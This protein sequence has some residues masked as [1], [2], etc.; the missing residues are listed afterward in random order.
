MTHAPDTLTALITGGS[1]GLG[2][3]CALILARSGHRL[4]LVSENQKELARA[5]RV[6]LDAGAARADTIC[7][8]LTTRDAAERLHGE[9][10][11]RGLVIDVLINC[12]GIYPTI[13]R[14]LTDISCIDAVVNLHVLAL[15]KLCLLFGRDM[16]ARRRGYILNVS[17]IASGFPDPASLTYGPS[18][19]YVRSF[20]EAIHCEWKEYGVK[21][22]CMTPG[23]ISTNFFTA[24]NVFIPP[25]IRR[26]L[27][28]AEDCARAG[29][30][31]MF[32]GTRRVTPGLYG[33]LQ[34]VILSII[35]RPLTYP[36]IK[37]SYFSMKN[38][39][40]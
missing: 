10:I 2:E 13:E 14:E 3:A 9:C 1:S 22:T 23:G 17:S 24:N 26:T 6:C 33:K 21:V 19:R 31:A 30:R 28:S 16:I 25:I 34:S 29:L 27:I 20:S 5:G 32:R 11:A 38:K 40:C 15:T 35:S 7:L 12:A 37:K 18:K 39:A 4:I 8:D 36:L